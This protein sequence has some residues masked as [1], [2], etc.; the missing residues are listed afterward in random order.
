MPA[1]GDPAGDELD[2]VVRAVIASA[3]G[4]SSDILEHLDPPV[5][6]RTLQSRL[7]ALVAAGRIERTGA[8][9]ATRYRLPRAAR[10]EPSPPSDEPSLSTDVVETLE[11]IRRPVTA[12]RPVGHDPSRLDDYAPNE[13]RWLR[14]ADLDRLRALDP[15]GGTRQPAGTYA[16]HILDRLLI[17]LSWN[18]SRLEGNTYSRLDT[19]RLIAF[20]AEASGKTRL[21]TQMILNHKAAIEFLVEGADSLELDPPTVRNLHALLADGLMPD[22]D[23]PGRLRDVEVRARP[24]PARSARGSRSSS[25]P[26][27]RAT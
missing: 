23:A 12:R 18:S 15:R 7:S 22:A 2:R 5:S 13:T 14:D 27:H 19:R 11:R 9:R 1:E 21:D 17:D 8:G 25:P 10:A 26:A 24:S 3:E 6:R 20:G 16:R 4:S